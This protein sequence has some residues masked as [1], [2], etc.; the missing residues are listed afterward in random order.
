M[1]ERA[2]SLIPFPDAHI[3]D[4]KIDGHASRQN[5]LLTIQYLLLG[6]TGK[7][8]LPER[9]RSPMRKNGL[10]ATTCF[11]FFLAQHNDPQYWEFNL[12]PSGDWSLYHMDAY[13]RVGF[14]EEMSIQ[15]LQFE[16]RHQAGC[17]SLNA[18]LDLSPLIQEGQPI[19]LAVS[20]VLQT[21]DKHE[22]FWA[23]VHPEAKPDFHIRDSF[24]IQ[25]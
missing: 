20:S 15:R 3:P 4:V 18:S 11:E 12:S 9:S 13:R 7:I 21:I 24:L 17:V 22:T 2:F 19:E 1:T 23:L 16:V 8:L 14:R 25:L 5:N 10:W 6:G